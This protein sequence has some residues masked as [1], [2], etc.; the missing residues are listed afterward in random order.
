M[1]YA[2]N[3]KTINI[4]DDEINRN[5]KG[6]KITKEE[7]I[8]V[9][10]EDN[11]YLEN[12]EQTALV[13][14]SKSVKI[15]H[16]ARSIDPSKPRKPRTTKIS[17]EKHQLFADLLNFLQENYENVSILNENKLISIKIGEKN[18]KLDLIEQRK[19]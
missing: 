2:F 11:E 15:R 6:L 13:E 4:P 7:A 16:E 1:K 18:F 8:Q 9:W 5:I 14:K 12:E 10:L 3:G 19:K 17:D